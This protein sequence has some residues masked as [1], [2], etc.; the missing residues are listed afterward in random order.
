MRMKATELVTRLGEAIARSKDPN[1]EVVF[2][3]ITYL[4]ARGDRPH[5]LELVDALRMERRDQEHRDLKQQVERLEA[6]LRS[7]KEAYG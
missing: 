3:S 4:H 2:D 6:Q 5:Q 7:Y 1:I